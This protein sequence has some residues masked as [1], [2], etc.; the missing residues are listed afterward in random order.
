MDGA[1]H[2]GGVETPDEVGRANTPYR[3]PDAVV[4]GI[5]PRGEIA[6]GSDGDFGWGKHS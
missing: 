3:L 2:R 6:A 5:I 1:P 4:R